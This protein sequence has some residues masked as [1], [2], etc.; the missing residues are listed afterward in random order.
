MHG[1]GTVIREYKS[2]KPKKQMCSGCY[3]DY[4]NTAVKDGCWSFER[5]RVVDKKGHRNIHSV[6]EDELKRK[7][8]SCWHAISK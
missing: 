7:T 3:N 5:A 8:L 1:Y 6:K 4:Y 2:L